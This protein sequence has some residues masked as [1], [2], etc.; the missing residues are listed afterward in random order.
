MLVQGRPHDVPR[1][2]VEAHAATLGTAQRN[3]FAAIVAHLPVPRHGGGITGVAAAFAEG[4]NTRDFFSNFVHARLAVFR[5][6]VRREAEASAIV[7][8]GSG[9]KIPRA[10]AGAAEDCHAPALRRARVSIVQNFGAP[11]PVRGQPH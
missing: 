10:A 1:A 7:P 8:L 9:S 5:A 4:Y 11:S 2:L 3:Q 6:A